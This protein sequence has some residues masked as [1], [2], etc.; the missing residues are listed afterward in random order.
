[1]SDMVDFTGVD[2]RELVKAVYELSKP[3]GMGFIHY[4]EG[5]IPEGILE[6]CV[7]AHE[8]D[9]SISLSLDYVLGRGCKFTLFR[10]K[11]KLLA[12]RDWYDHTPQ[13]MEALMN[14]FGIF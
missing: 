12:Y 14:K 9:K 10:E 8:N 3:I 13:Q 11:G 5:P 1:M 4:E 2:L 6:V 7:T